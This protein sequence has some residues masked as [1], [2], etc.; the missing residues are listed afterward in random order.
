[1]DRVWGATVC[2]IRDITRRGSVP[3]RHRECKLGTN[4]RSVYA[5]LALN[6]LRVFWPRCHVESAS[7]PVVSSGRFCDREDFLVFPLTHTFA[8]S[9]GRARTMSETCISSGGLSCGDVWVRD[10][11]A[12]SGLLDLNCAMILGLAL[13]GIIFVCPDAGHGARNLHLRSNVSRGI[14]G[15][16][17]CRTSVSN[18]YPRRWLLMLSYMIFRSSFLLSD[19]LDS[20]CPTAL[21]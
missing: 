9:T 10:C 15:D 16:G 2:P 19:P 17:R 12:H 8:A 14:F 4:E 11:S 5:A 20:T 13:A 21:T 18:P 6:G 7:P 3:A 1:M